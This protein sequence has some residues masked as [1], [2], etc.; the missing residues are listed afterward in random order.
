LTALSWPPDLRIGA[1]SYLNTKPLIH[2]LDAASLTLDVPAN[3]AWRFYDG[4]LDVALLPFFAVLKAGGGRLVD[5]VAIACCGEV[6][7]VYVAGRGDFEECREIYLDPSSRSSAA[8]LRVLLAEYYPESHCV[9]DEAGE[10]PVNAAR[11]LIGDPAI[12]FRQHHGTEWNYHDLGA[13]WRKH[14]GLPFVFAV[15]AVAAEMNPEIGKALRAA[16]VAGLSARGEIASGG[17]DP[18]FTRHYLTEYIHYDIGPEEK[19]AMRVFET[20]SRQHGI[21]PA[22][23]PVQITWC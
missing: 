14:T 16:K 19:Q 13:L 23:E 11:L 4:E 22:G 18:D 9:V 5:D 6:Y 21:L 8:L 2:S 12:R 7:S 17:T 3:L 10:I 20:L 15:W 1:V